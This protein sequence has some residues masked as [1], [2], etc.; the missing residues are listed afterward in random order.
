MLFRLRLDCDLGARRGIF[1]GAPGPYAGPCGNLKFAA[2]MEGPAICKTLRPTR[3]IGVLLIAILGCA[4]SLSAQALRQAETLSASFRR[5]AEQA[6][7][8]VVA[9]RP[10]VP[11]ADDLGAAAPYIPPAAA[12]YVPPVVGQFLGRPRSRPATEVQTG[13]S[14]V[15]V[16]ARRGLILTTEQAAFFSPQVVIVLADGRELQPR[17]LARDSRSG[18]ALITVDPQFLSL[19]EVQWS[20]RERLQLGDWVLSLA[21]SSSGAPF[22]SAGIV[23]GRA[24]GHPIT[25]YEQLLTDATVGSTGSGGPLVDLE[26]RVVGI[27]QVRFDSRGWPASVRVI[28]ADLARRC[29]SDL[30]EFGQVRRGYLGLVVEPRGIGGLDSTSGSA[31]LAVTGLTPEGPA[32]LAGLR[33]GDVIV[34]LDGQPIV[35]LRSLSQT[36]EDSPI[37]R[38]FRLTI[39]RQGKR[40]EIVVVSHP[41]SLAQGLSGNDPN[42][43]VR[44]PQLRLRPPARPGG[45]S[46]RPVP[47]EPPER[48]P[49]A[50]PATPPAP[51]DPS[52]ALPEPLELEGPLTPETRPR[53]SSR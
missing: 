3:R 25:P 39:E 34:A 44:P 6:L 28:P 26:G 35:E 29:A 14:G 45:Q 10:A 53:S 17:R 2:M 18:L 24:P 48:A 27:N 15:V 38:E 32:A 40:L 37:G 31:G 30:A 5:A 19:S 42:L 7:P 11:A 41:R 16:D 22:I 36:V 49:D 23:S 43:P 33:A 21:R 12:P 47:A 20:E 13:G 1:S 52:P 8:S 51:A 50:A 46:L 9:I 4:G